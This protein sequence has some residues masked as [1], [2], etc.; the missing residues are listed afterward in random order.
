ME[1]SFLTTK[2]LLFAIVPEMQPRA[3]ELTVREYTAWIEAFEVSLSPK[4]AERFGE[5]SHET[6]RK[7]SEG[8]RRSLLSTDPTRGERRLAGGRVLSA[9]SSNLRHAFVE[10]LEEVQNRYILFFEPQ[11]VSSVGWHDL[12][13]K[14]KKRKGEIRTRS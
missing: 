12:E 11:G 7:A 4:M 5:F 8:Y 3:S 14:P 13:V 2:A 10:I 1:T 9:Q 6:I